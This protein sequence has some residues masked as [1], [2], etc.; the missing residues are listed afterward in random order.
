MGLFG[1]FPSVLK[2]FHTARK[3]FHAVAE[4]GLEPETMG[5]YAFLLMKA[6]LPPLE[7]S[8]FEASVMRKMI[9]A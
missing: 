7:M 1:C 6:F 8:T 5:F 4:R 9:L 2:F 3:P